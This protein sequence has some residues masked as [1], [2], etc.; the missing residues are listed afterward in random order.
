M[1]V[2]SA[3]ATVLAT[4]NISKALDKDGKEITPLL[5]V[6]GGIIRWALTVTYFGIH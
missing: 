6:S 4:V 3:I 2:W 1:I 5:E